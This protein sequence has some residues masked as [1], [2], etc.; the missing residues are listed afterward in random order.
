M[1]HIIYADGNN[2][3]SVTLFTQV[4]I[5]TTLL[6][7]KVLNRTLK[8]SISTTYLEPLKSSKQNNKNPFGFIH[9]HLFCPFRI[10]YFILLKNIKTLKCIYECM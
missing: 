7:E 8:A 4:N 10:K 9:N 2:R 1:L 5:C 3:A 6:E